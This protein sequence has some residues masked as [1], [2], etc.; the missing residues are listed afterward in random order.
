MAGTNTNRSALTRATPANVFMATALGLGALV[1]G[2]NSARAQAA[3]AST[4]PSAAAEIKDD[5]KIIDA[6]MPKLNTLPVETVATALEPI[7]D[8]LCTMGV[9]SVSD[10]CSVK[11][12]TPA[13]SVANSLGIIGA[14]ATN[15]PTS[16]IALSALKGSA[17][18]LDIV[19]SMGSV[20]AL[21]DA[22]PPQATGSF[23]KK[24]GP[25]N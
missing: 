16:P 8:S 9:V 20:K 15:A 5:M 25:S 1:P 24:T 13:Q 21:Q 18:A 19:A 22:V 6:A 7:R 4:S 23:F 12:L 11:P 17:A 10:A 2:M 14:V 3:S